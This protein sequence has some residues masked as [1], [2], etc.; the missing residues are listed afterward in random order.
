MSCWKKR[1]EVISDSMWKENY[2]K[3][4]WVEAADI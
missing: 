2:I 3:Y 1:E 4:E